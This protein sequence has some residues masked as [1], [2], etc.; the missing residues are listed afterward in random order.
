M[1]EIVLVC[2][3]ALLAYTAKGI[4]GAA[5][6]VVFNAGLLLALA[7]GF[8]GDI[9][10]ADG[11]AWVALT[12]AA[13]GLFM[14]ALLRRE[15][16]AEPFTTRMLAGLLPSTLVFTFVLTVA[17]PG[18][19]A[20]SLAIVLV[21]CGIW[22]STSRNSFGSMGPR[23]ALQLAAPCGLLAGVIGGLFGM[24]GPISFL[25]LG[26]ASADPAEFRRRTVLLFAVVNCV[27][28][29]QLAIMGEYTLPRLTMT[30]WT[31]PV[32]AGATL[33][34]MWLH[35]YVKPGPFRLGLGL[36]VVL[37]GAVAL[38]KLAIV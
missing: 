37:A 29:A 1:Y 8:A 28:V 30:A 34:G 26:P 12:D 16:R 5:S 7:F 6:A 3:L 9:S 27:R 10:L 20:L 17:A 36:I 22:L 38:L 31:L 33:F 35:R 14:L 19:L 24:A 2:G 32:V 25:L 23:R 15:I 4:T 13:S 21:G 11:L 18:V